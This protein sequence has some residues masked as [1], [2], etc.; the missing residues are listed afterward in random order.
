MEQVVGKGVVHKIFGRG[1]IVLADARY[2]T[3]QFEDPEVGEKKFLFPQAFDSIIAFEDGDLQQGA[4]G[5]AE[6]AMVDRRKCST[7]IALRCQAEAV[8]RAHDRKTVR[9]TVKKK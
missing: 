8:T 5:A 9:K 2:F 3:V 4:R 6:Q 7:K 1:V